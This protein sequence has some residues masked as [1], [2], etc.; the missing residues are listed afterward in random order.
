MVTKFELATSFQAAD[1]T[2]QEALENTFPDA[3][4]ARYLPRGKGKPGSK[5]R[6]A[7]DAR[8]AARIA[9]ESAR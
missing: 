5:L 1:D 3:H 4:T 9:W 8:E 7:Y 6:A 2:W